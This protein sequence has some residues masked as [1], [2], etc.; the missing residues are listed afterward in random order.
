MVERK[1]PSVYIQETSGFSNTIVEVETAAPAFVG[2]TQ[3]AALGTRGL[4]MTPF[5]I[6][7]FDAFTT[8]FGG[9]PNTVF[10]LAL[11]A[12]GG[13]TASAAAARYYLYYALRLFFDN[14]GGD[15]YI[16]SVGDYSAPIVKQD[17]LAG[18]DSLK[19]EPVPTL[20]VIPDAMSLTADDAVDVQAQTLKHCSTL[21]SRMAILDLYGGDQPIKALLPGKTQT[22]IDYFRAAIGAVGLDFGAAYYPW[23]ETSLV[24]LDD[25]D[26]AH[27]TD[28]GLKT[29][30]AKL[31]GEGDAAI[32]KLVAQA[33]PWAVPAPA[34]TATL[35]P[36]A[37]IKLLPADVAARQSLAHATLLNVSPDY[38][39]AMSA[40]RAELNKAPPSGAIAGVYARTD[41]TRGVFKAPAGTGVL[42]AVAPLAVVT[43]E[44][45]ADLNLP[46]DGKAINAIRTI[47]GM[48]VM[49]WGARTLDGNS[50]DMRYIN[51]RRTVI[52][53]EQSIKAALRAYVFQPNTPETW[54]LVAGMIG[55]FL[56]NQWK[57]GALFGATPDEAFQVAVGLGL[58]MT[59]EDILNGYMNVTVKAAIV[60]P[61][62]FIVLTF[63]QTMQAA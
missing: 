62:E 5:R 38:Q 2:Y 63:Q 37:Q 52:M 7:N 41:F 25:V 17:L 12:P 42:S 11:G 27:L 36:A 19:S 55:S 31:Q 26:I 22:A 56:R 20:I 33:A 9:P 59:A 35:A 6:S 48:G 53:W 28:K 50:Q 58:T 44:D 3:K 45:Q 8:G 23:I 15:C 24:S 13:W 61:D 39:N 54:S 57:A 40:V 34:A 60:R 43:D 4:A 18:L 10:D 32:A 29:L 16:V 49:V 14:G 1:T 30:I 47:P 21:A 46:L 51:V